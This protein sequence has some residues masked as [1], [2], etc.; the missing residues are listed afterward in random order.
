MWT[1][2]LLATV[3]FLRVSYRIDLDVYRIAVETWVHGGDIYGRLPETGVGLSLPFIYPP[4]AAILLIPLWPIPFWLASVV[5]TLTTITL[6]A[7]TLGL[8]LKSLG[9]S[10]KWMVILPAVLFLEPVRAT[11]G[12]G[13][14]NV[15]LLAMVAADCLL[16]STRWP[17]GLLLGLAAA[18]KLTPAALVL[19]FLLRRDFRAAAT[20]ALSFL[21]ATT[22]GFV[23]APHA[24]LRYWTDTIFHT[25]DKVGTFYIANQSIHGVLIRLGL[26]TLGWLPLAI[27][28]VV[29]AVSAMRHAPPVLAFGVNALAMLL[30]SPISWSQHWVW[31]LPMLLA[32][33][34]AGHRVL[35][36][37]G[38]VLFTVA[39]H[40]WFPRQPWNAW[41]N[42]AGNA[43]VLFAV[44]VLVFLTVCTA[45]GR[46]APGDPGPRPP[47]PSRSTAPG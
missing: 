6:V 10:P 38:T 44:T 19:F 33:A 22:V 27:A 41:E 13:Q 24:S 34:V 30:L 25:D 45:R 26:G 4:I 39:P 32:L 8:T 42:V 21:A 18:I 31:C 3:W 20:A 35:A 37:T 5:L 1:A 36:V 28:V 29:C 43:Y 11:I 15:I 12:Y 7:T 47:R 14:V 40:W 46:T 17:R 2:T 9:R 16:R 23:V